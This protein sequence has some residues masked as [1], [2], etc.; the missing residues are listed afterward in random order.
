M[1]LTP[2]AY[3]KSM[4]LGSFDIILFMISCLLIRAMA[5]TG[6][7]TIHRELG[8]ANGL[9]LLPISFLVCLIMSGA[10]IFSATSTMILFL[11][12]MSLIAIF[13]TIVVDRKNIYLACCLPILVNILFLVSH[14]LGYDPVIVNPQGEPGGVM[15]NAPRMCMYLAI[16]LPI[17]FHESWAVAGVISS[18]GLIYGEIYLPAFFAILC[19]RATRWDLRG[20]QYTILAGL[21]ISQHSHII[22][23][24]KI[25]LP[26]WLPTIE[27]ALA[28]PLF[29][30]GLGVFHLVSR[31]FIPGAYYA[32]NAFS[33][34][35][36]LFYSVGIA[37]TGAAIYCL[38]RFWKMKDSPYRLSILF[39]AVLMLTEYPLEVPKLW[40][41]IL[42]IAAAAWAYDS[43]CKQAEEKSG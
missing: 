20:F 43:D 34:W 4:P 16:V 38:Y 36:Q 3:T 19:I 37:G 35:I 27:Q 25:R 24:I 9:Q 2:I 31:Q 42:I 1:L 13:Q 23:S 10:S 11:A 15:G 8:V 14:E 26:V 33:S 28:H 5:F 40:M 7:Q 29:G 39:T 17:I 12:F 22:Q 30:N 32:D 6:Y 21:M 18:L 41:V